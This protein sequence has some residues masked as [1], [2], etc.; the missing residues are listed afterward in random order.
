MGSGNIIHSLKDVDW[1]NQK[2]G[3]PWA[4][5]MRKQANEYLL[6]H[7]HAQ[8]INY[9]SNGEEWGKAINSAEH[10]LPLLYIVA[11]EEPGERLTL[12]NDELTMGSMSMTS[13]LIDAPNSLLHGVIEN[14]N[15]MFN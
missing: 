4:I 6:A 15:K 3:H 9:K 11:L 10:Y 14:K 7:Q 8:L 12:F 2:S 1:H 5:K 13:F